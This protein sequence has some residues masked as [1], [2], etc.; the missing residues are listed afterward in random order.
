MVM[1]LL[2]D[3]CVGHLIKS[4]KMVFRTTHMYGKISNSLDSSVLEQFAHHAYFIKTGIIQ[5]S[6]LTEIPLYLNFD[7]GYPFSSEISFKRA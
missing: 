3:G 5:S 1:A 6:R 4:I 2:K 7:F